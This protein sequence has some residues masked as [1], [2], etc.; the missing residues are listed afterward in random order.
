MTEHPEHH[1]ILK[2][3]QQRKQNLP[4]HHLRS[5]KKHKKSKN[6][7]VLSLKQCI[8]DFNKSMQSVSFLQLMSPKQTMNTAASTYDQNELLDSTQICKFF[9]A[10]KYDTQWF[11]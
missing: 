2:M 3:K 5:H 8:D 7:L 11:C 10:K 4:N 9:K 1:M 6:K